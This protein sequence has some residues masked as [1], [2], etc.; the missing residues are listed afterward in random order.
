MYKKLYEAFNS[1]SKDFSSL[2]LDKIEYKNNCQSSEVFYE[3]TLSEMEFIKGSQNPKFTYYIR[4]FEISFVIENY[5]WKIE[6]YLPGNVIK[7]NS[8]S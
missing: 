7:R 3:C 5:E 4:P 1:S 8:P 6:K 2:K